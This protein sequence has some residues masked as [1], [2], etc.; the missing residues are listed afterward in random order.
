MFYYHDQI[1]LLILCSV[2]N[3]GGHPKN[4]AW[5]GG[6][7]HCEC[8]HGV[9]FWAHGGKHIKDNVIAIKAVSFNDN[10]YIITPR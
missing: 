5:S 6:P 4:V 9:D 1:F 7:L 2:Y 3:V 8:E 10:I